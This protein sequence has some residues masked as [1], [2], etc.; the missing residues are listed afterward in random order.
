[1]CFG[2]PCKIEKISK[3]KAAVLNDGKVFDIDTSLLSKVKKGDWILVQGDIGF[4]KLSA[5]E[6][7]ECLEVFDQFSKPKKLNV[8]KKGSKK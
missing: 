3:N 4:K 8:R 1:M 2:I 5:D 7:K 6:A